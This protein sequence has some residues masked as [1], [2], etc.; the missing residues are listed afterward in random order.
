MNPLPDHPLQLAPALKSLLAEVRRRIRAYVWAE[1]IAVLLIVLGLT[2]WTT[3]GFDWVF[4]PPAALRIGILVATAAL[5]VWVLFFWILR[6]A[7]VRLA[8][9]SMA[10]VLERRFHHQLQDS[11][12]AS[13]ELADQPP[14]A[15]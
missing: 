15:V 8:D 7:W 10:I 6:R 14:G 3:L 1:G 13:V 12:L 9:R 5:V 11:L 4:E 2:F